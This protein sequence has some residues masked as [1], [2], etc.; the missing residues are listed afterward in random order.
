MIVDTSAADGEIIWRPDP[1]R[2]TQVQR[3]AAFLR[4]SGETVGDDYASLWKW[5]VNDPDAFWSALADFAG[6]N[7]G[8]APGPV[9]DGK[10]MPDTE[11]FPGRTL[12]FAQ[13]LLS[14]RDG[15][16]L[17]SVAEGGDPVPMSF[18]ELRGQVGA[19]AAHLRSIGVEEGDRVVAVLPN[20]PEAIVALLATVS[21]GAVWSV[22]APE[23]G[24]G[25][26]ASRFGQLQ[27]KVLIAAPGYELAGKVRDRSS[28]LVEVV[29][30]LQEVQQVVWVTGRVPSISIPEV[31]VASVSW[32]DIVATPIEPQ[33][34]PVAFNHPIWVLFSS[35]TT[36]TPKG[37]VHGHGGALLEE[38]NLL[39]FGGDV[40]DGDVVLNVASTSWVVWNSLVSTLAVGAV[41]VLMDGNPT[42]PTVDRIWEV[43]AM[44]RATVLGVGAGFL[45]ACAKTDLV[46]GRDHDLSA[47]REVQVTGS[48]LSPAGFRWVYENVG[49]VWLVSM[50]GGTDIVGCFVGG[51]PTEP[52]RVGYIQAP[53]LGVKVES[54]D[55]SGRPT[56][57][58]GELVVTEP[59][60]SMP[61]YLWGDDGERYRASY[62]DTYPGVWRH[63]DF[64][65]I[66]ER[67]ILILGRSD[68][69]LNRNGIRL[70]SADLYAIVEAL[71]EVAESLVIGAEIGA[72]G[73][74]MPL[75]VQ[76][77]E[78]A[79]EESARASIIAAIRRE[80]SARYLPD[81]L[82]VMRGIPHTKT[83]KKLEVPI[84]RLIQGAALDDVVDLGSVDDPSLLQEYADFASAY[85]Q[86]TLGGE[87]D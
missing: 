63:G 2:E 16:A 24:P 18:D 59:M 20:V 15:T 83:G 55:A 28:E 17:I 27:P 6:V 21:I 49:D 66:S 58:K 68:S 10:P 46:P 14:D 42:F 84:K 60:P 62:F 86:R 37:I 4:D 33:Y 35:G 80:L 79:R 41:P 69:T 12:N 43:A 74:Y 50:S 65:E 11:W 23:F 64:I 39:M 57:E 25:A 61:L 34:V 85:H 73:Y 13:H 40:S 47:L 71:P 32:D 82:I 31:A 72:D 26:I 77:A 30:G 29:D 48:P 53:A 45:H 87:D 1:E 51:A 5:S 70:G 75:F 36:G 44:T 22:C 38:I 81:E 78:G 9:R 19:L 7:L 67:G 8:G 52:V 54:W 3:F 56:T 76:L